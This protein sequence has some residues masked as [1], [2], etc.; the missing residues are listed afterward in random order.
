M[1]H[2]EF[3]QLA[4][5][6]PEH[7]A[8]AA[9]EHAGQ[10]AECAGYLSQMRQLDGLMKRA[11][12]VPAPVSGN[13]TPIRTVV[14]KDRAPARVFALAASMLL[15]V[16]LG[17]GIW[18]ASSRDTLAADVI[19]HVQEEPDAMVATDNRVTPAELDDVLRRAGVRLKSGTQTVS[20]ARTCEFR[21]TT[22]PHLVVQTREGPITV[23][24][25]ANEPVKSA[26]SFD[27]QGYAG[28]IL[29]SGRGAIAIIANTRTALDEAAA[30]VAA[31]VEW[32]N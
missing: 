18:I 13:V 30:Q 11:M 16:L 12:E 21:N 24:V 20:I 14:L 19:V 10:C 31:S 32:I 2:S 1:Q 5:A 26:R 28:T 27:E 7:L 15:A 29:P 6:D 23:L 4:G 25:L 8:A 3:R 9:Q 17:A 22:I